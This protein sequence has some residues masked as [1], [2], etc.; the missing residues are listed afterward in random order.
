MKKDK[1]GKKR[2]KKEK[3]E[4]RRKKEKR[5]NRSFSAATVMLS[6][7]D[8]SKEKISSLGTLENI[9]ELEPQCNGF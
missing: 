6:P 9:R 4:K 8:F 2:K 7:R 5:E 3:R 1:I